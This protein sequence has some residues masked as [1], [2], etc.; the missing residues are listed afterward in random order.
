MWQ[1][2]MYFFSGRSSNVYIFLIGRYVHISHL[3]LVY[4]N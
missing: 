2:V 3:S 4:N 1:C